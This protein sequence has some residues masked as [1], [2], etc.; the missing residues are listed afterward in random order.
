MFRLF[1]RLPLHHKALLLEATLWLLLVRPVVGLH[2]KYWTRLLGAQQA[3]TPAEDDSRHR[4]AVQEVAWSLRNVSPHVFWRADCLPQALAAWLMLRR[5]GVP[6]TLYLGAQFTPD[7]AALRAHA[8]V[9]AGSVI[10][11]GAQGHQQ[12]SVVSAFSRP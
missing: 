4:R 12:F 3:E 2:I 11:T 9:R 8:W 5:R 10:V 6:C 1:L 7:R